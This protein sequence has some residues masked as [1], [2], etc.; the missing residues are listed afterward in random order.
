V[1]QFLSAF[2]SFYKDKTQFNEPMNLEEAI[3]K[4]KFLYDKRKGISA[5]QKSWD[6]NKEGKMDQRKKGFNPPFIR[7]RPQE[8]FKGSHLK[9][10]K[11]LYIP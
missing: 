10:I 6:D 11:K 8:I 9:A 5:F 3:R 2:P 7:N 4:D 1:L